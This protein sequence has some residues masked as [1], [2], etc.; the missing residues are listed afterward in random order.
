MRKETVESFRMPSKKHVAFREAWERTANK[1]KDVEYD[2]PASHTVDPS[3][4]DAFIA[5]INKRV[6]ALERDLLILAENL[7]QD[8]PREEGEIKVMLPDL[9]ARVAIQTGR[10]V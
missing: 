5:M 4:E 3:D 9:R 2:Q 10:Q 6:S 7:T 8:M 1:V